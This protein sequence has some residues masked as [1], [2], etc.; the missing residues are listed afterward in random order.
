MRKNYKE[1]SANFLMNTK[2]DFGGN[3]RGQVTIF[4]IIAIAIVGLVA[5]TVFFFPRIQE[6]IAP[7]TFSASNYLRECVEPDLKPT[8][9]S[10][11]KHGG[12]TDPEGFILYEGEK[13]KYL[14]YSSEY[15]QTCAIQE[16]IVK[17]NFE[18]QLNT[19]LTS[20]ASQCFSNLKREYERRGFAVSAKEAETAIEI[21]PG[22]IRATFAAPFTI[23][24]G[25]TTQTF[26]KFEADI[27]SEMYELLF[28][29]QS[30]VEFEA[31]YGDSETTLYMQ[32]YPNLKIDKR[33]L[34]DGSKIYILSNVVTKESF[35]FASRS[36][37][38]PPGYG[39]E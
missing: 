37:A 1:N 7:G 4:V 21:I 34:D 8:I 32:Y 23:T 20:R 30:I 38:W 16:P 24:K 36:Q 10:L 39:T 35:T 17:G 14:C 25:E 5:A 29:A 31:T 11:A 9:E 15:Y 13:V 22:K 18:T 26:E 2:E 33:K 6:A 12:Y 28:I 27:S 19:L 3:K